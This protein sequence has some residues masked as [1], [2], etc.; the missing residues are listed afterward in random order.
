MALLQL[1]SH[2]FEVLPLT[3]QRL[4]QQAD[5]RWP[6]L[7]RLGR[8][9]ALQYLG[10]GEKRITIS[11]LLFPEAIGGWDKFRAFERT[12]GA[13]QPMMMVLGTGHVFG[14]VVITSISEAHAAIG[15]AGLPRKLSFDIEV[16]RYGGDYGGFSGWLF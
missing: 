5:F 6:A 8:E 11:G 9:P 10:P 3:Y 2:Q 16:A 1:G 4:W 13:G 14:R 7:E 12:A 15:Y